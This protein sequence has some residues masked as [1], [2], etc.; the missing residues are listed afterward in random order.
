MYEYYPSALYFNPTTYFPNSN[1]Y[2]PTLVAMLSFIP[3]LK[4]ALSQQ[5]SLRAACILAAYV[6]T[7]SNRYGVLCTDNS[8]LA[9]VFVYYIFLHPLKAYPGP[10]LAKVTD[11]YAGYHAIMMRLH[12]VT[13]EDH[14]RYGRVIRHGP[15]KL[16]FNSAEAIKGWFP[17]TCVTLG[18]FDIYLNKRISKSH[19]YLTSLPASTS[20]NIWS[21]VDKRDHRSRQR[22][23]GPIFSDRSLQQFEPSMIKE[24]DVFLRVL[25]ASCRAPNKQDLD[26]TKQCDYLTLDIVLASSR[27]DTRIVL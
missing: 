24:I 23:I 3:L 19:A 25:L 18:P 14:K 27:S 4:Q 22:L 12:L 26:M 11:A 8:K 5:L 10:L 13:W 16:V 2:F 21:V 1:L 20:E 15:N 6:C 17:G 7:S 9:A